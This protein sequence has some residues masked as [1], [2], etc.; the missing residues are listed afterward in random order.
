[1]VLENTRRENMET[2][3]LKEYLEPN[4]YPGRGIIIGKSEDQKYGVIC[5]FIMGRSENSRNRIFVKEDQGIR[6]QA[7]DPSKLADPSLIIYWPMRVWDQQTIITNGDQTDTIYE[8]LQKGDTFQ[9]A[10]LTREFEPD[11]PNYTPRISGILH[12]AANDF[13]FEMSILKSDRGNGSSCNRYFYRYECAQPGEGRM[14]HT[15]QGDGAI[16]PSFEGEPV[17]VELKGSMDQITDTLWE[18]LN[19]ENK[20]SLMVQFIDLK[21]G[22][23]TSRIVNKNQ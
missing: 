9:E 20:V 12:R 7:F 3:T 5:Y 11:A 21:T 23:A 8:G 1:M 10:L 6:T 17:V 4:A 18:S 15:Y 22:A 19:F 2:V 16:L 14:I 13:S